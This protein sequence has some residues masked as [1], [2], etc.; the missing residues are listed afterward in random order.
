MPTTKYLAEGTSLQAV[1]DAIRTKTGDSGQLTFPAGF[2]DA[3]GSISGSGSGGGATIKMIH[4]YNL[5]LVTTD[6]W[7]MSDFVTE[8]TSSHYCTGCCYLNDEPYPISILYRDDLD[9]STAY[10]SPFTPECPDGVYMLAFNVSRNQTTG[11][12]NSI[13]LTGAEYYQ[14]NEQVDFNQDNIGDWYIVSVQI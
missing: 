14:L 5:Q 2:V 4:G 9:P 3:I 12:I 7:S 13:E 8:P 6:G 1:A 10:A 11:A